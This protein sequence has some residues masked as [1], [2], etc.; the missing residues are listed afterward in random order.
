MPKQISEYGFQAQGF[1]R[2]FIK[3]RLLLLGLSETNQTYFQ[4]LF[5]KNEYIMKY[6]PIYYLLTDNK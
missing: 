4:I 6:M 1:Q 5:S 3:M 2:H